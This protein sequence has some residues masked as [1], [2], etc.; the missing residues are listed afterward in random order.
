[1]RTAGK[2]HGIKNK[3]TEGFTLAELLIVVAIIAVLVAVSIPILMH[4]LENTKKTVCESNRRT[5]VRQIVLERMEDE[6]FDEADAREVLEKSDAYCPAGGEYSVT[7]NELLVKV[8]CDKHGGSSGGTEDTEISGEEARK[9]YI[10]NCR[11]S[12]LDY[13]AKNPTKNNN[14][15]RQAIF[16]QYGGKWPVLTV[17]GKSY[18]IQP[19][20]KKPEKD[21]NKP[22]EECVWLFAR[23]D[24]GTGA[25]WSVPYVYN[26]KEEKWYGS[27]TWNGSIGGAANIVYDDTD[28]L[29]HAIKTDTHNGHNKWT[30]LTDYKES[31]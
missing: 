25:G 18:H 26:V 21:S 14:E 12:A 15:V 5:L 27:T 8:E 19:F 4:S 6:G 20:Y 11:K 7:V 17:G 24:G 9:E 1:M 2:K 13:I 31:Y 10:E 30:E 28:A 29:D 16:E 3:D 22:I 23:E